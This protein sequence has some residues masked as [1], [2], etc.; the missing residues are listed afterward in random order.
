MKKS[1][2]AVACAFTV[3]LGLAGFANTLTVTSLAD[4]FPAAT[5]GTFRYE[6]EHSSAGDTIVFADS[7][8]GGTINMVGVSTADTSF[9]IAHAL[10]IEGNGVTINGGW[11]G[12]V[13]S[14]TGTR[15]FLTAAGQGKTTIK[16]LNLVNG[17]G[18]NWYQ[19]TEKFFLGGAVN[20]GSP[21]RLE[22]CQLVNNCTMD[23][24]AGYSYPVIRGGG[25]ICTGSDLEIVSCYFGTNCVPNGSSSYGGAICQSGGSLFVED[26]VF[27]HDYTLAFGGGAAYLGSGVEGA[28]F[29]NCSFLENTIAGNQ[30]GGAIRCDMSSGSLKLFGCVFRGCCGSSGMVSRGGA[31]WCSDSSHAALTA[32]GCEFSDCNAQFGAAVYY[33]TDKPSLFVNCT[34]SGNAAQTWAGA[35]E[36]FVSLNFVNCTVVGEYC[37]ESDGGGL[38][39]SAQ[40]NMLNSVFAYNYGTS[41]LKSS[42]GSQNGN[43]K[44]CSLYKG[45]S[46]APFGETYTLATSM[47]DIGSATKLFAGY[48]MVSDMRGYGPNRVTLPHAV[49]MPRLGDDD[50]STRVVEIDPDGVLASDGYPVRVNDDYS[51]VEYSDDGGNTWKQFFKRDG[52]DTT[53]LTRITADQRGVPYKDGLT[54]VGAATVAASPVDKV[55]PQGVIVY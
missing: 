47:D 38:F 12:V 1:L 33:Q 46:T 41:S 23:R 52:A 18:A 3:M 10:T 37:A 7:I 35:I 4:E 29:R 42:D 6:L 28:V 51:Y 14:A 31:I 5:P 45:A 48:E 36:T 44:L 53:N 32:V 11:D 24:N 27:D 13:A 26:S 40:L 54:P 30:H 15:I 19:T 39:A 2:T 55:L 20:A 22:N 16:N 9:V 21:I 17:H 49:V 43:T 25:A 8:K 34:F 50:Y